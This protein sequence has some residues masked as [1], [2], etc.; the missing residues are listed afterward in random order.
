M[1]TGK[2]IVSD[3]VS[4]PDARGDLWNF[5]VVVHRSYPALGEGPF[6]FFCL[7]PNCYAWSALRRQIS[8]RTASWRGLSRQ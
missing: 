7:Q 1:L 3:R 2:Q 6:V 5:R 4:L 8:R